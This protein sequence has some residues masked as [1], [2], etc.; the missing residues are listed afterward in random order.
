MAAEVISMK[1]KDRMTCF[2]AH[3]SPLFLKV[4]P[5]VHYIEATIA[6]LFLKV[7]DYLPVP[8]VTHKMVKMG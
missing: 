8:S 3:F 7:L 6:V 4:N 5:G 1:K 2:L